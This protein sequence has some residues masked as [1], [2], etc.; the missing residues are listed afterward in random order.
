MDA[1]AEADRLL[2]ESGAV[3]IRNH[4]HEVWQLPNGKKFV[5]AKTPSDK[6][7]ARNNL[8]DLKHALGIQSNGGQ[9]GERRE[10]TVRPKRQLQ[11]ERFDDVPKL[12]TGLADKLRLLGVSEDRLRGDIE[13]LDAQN[14]FLQQEISDLINENEQMEALLLAF[15]L[16]P[17]LCG[18]CRLKLLIGSPSTTRATA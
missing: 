13:F 6:D 5:R 14:V 8:S 12:N 16:G 4:K 1:H 18:W 7:S 11:R 17:C 10:K 2:K 9:V 15:Q 3:L